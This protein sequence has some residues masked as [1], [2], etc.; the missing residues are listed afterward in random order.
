M[1]Q[2]E[3]EVDHVSAIEDPCNHENQVMEYF[4]CNAK[5]HAFLEENKNVPKTSDNQDGCVGND[6]EN[7]RTPISEE[8][9]NDIV[10]VRVRN[11][12]T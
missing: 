2:N 10:E 1:P 4:K 9:E 8:I 3:F 12:N 11:A 5:Q 6:D 7:G